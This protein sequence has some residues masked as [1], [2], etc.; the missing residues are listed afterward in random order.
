MEIGIKLKIKKEE[1]YASGK[2]IEEIS[3]E[4]SKEKT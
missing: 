3:N 4:E 2:Y 1:G